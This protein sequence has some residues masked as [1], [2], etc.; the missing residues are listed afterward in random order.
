MVIMASGIVRGRVRTTAATTT[1]VSRNM[2]T[3]TELKKRLRMSSIR[4]G[5]LGMAR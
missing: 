4:A 5:K 2:A 1:T 3:M